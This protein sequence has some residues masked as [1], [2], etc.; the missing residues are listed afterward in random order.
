VPI[1]PPV[2]V[3]GFCLIV[4]TGETEASARVLFHPHRVEPP[5]GGASQLMKNGYVNG[6]GMTQLGRIVP[7][8][9]GPVDKCR[10]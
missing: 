9:P 1:P 6:D 4:S 8:N 2:R 7:N 10:A 5:T 3:L